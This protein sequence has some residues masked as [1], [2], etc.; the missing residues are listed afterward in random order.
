M[1]AQFVA[2]GLQAQVSGVFLGPMTDELGWTRAE[3]TLATSIGTVFMG[4]IGF[5]VGALVDRRGAR[6]LML[7]GITIVGAALNAE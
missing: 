5:F 7:T 3:F 1:V 6:P 4:L 2:V